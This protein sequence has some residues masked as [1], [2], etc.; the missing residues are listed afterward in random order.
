MRMHD[1]PTFRTKPPVRQYALAIF[2]TLVALLLQ[3]LLRPLYGTFYPYH[4]VWLAV[5]FS[6]W[7]C[8]LGPSIAATLLSALGVWYLFLPPPYSFEVQDRTEVFGAIGFLLIAA[9]IVALGETVRRASASRFRLAAIVDSSDDA[10]ISKNLD[11]IITSWN[12][13]AERLFGWTPEE[14]IGRPITLVIPPELQHEEEGILRRLRAGQRVDHYETIR[15]SK[16]GTRRDLSLTI[17]PVRDARG[18]VVGASKI[19]RDIGERKL[20]EAMREKAQE[21][22]EH[23]VRERTAELRQKNEELTRQAE[24]IHELSARLLRLQDEERRRIARELHDGVGQLLAA[25]SMTVSAALT[26]CQ[27]GGANTAAVLAD[28]MQLLDQANKEVRTMSYLLHPP[29]LEEMGLASALRWYV[30]GFVQR[31]QIDVH[32][33]V[34]ASFERLSEAHELALFRIVQE[35]LTNIHRHSGS[36]EAKVILAREGDA[37]HLEVSDNGRGIP[38]ETQA[39][40]NAAGTPGVGLRGMRERIRQLGGQLGIHSSGAGTQVAVTLPV[41]D[42]NT[43]AATA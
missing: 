11:G 17:S 5:V 18:R 3:S 1:T 10:I 9:C 32:L 35:C 4:A 16:D 33:D 13:G 12:A 6:A 2:A 41:T 8:G 38:P 39:E 19:A 29:L 30:E 14:A 20:I 22:L 21:E 42:P 25:L 26:E 43:V 34:A 24:T 40:L 23:R 36:T 15:V 28:G 31:S 27:N 7:Y 37:I